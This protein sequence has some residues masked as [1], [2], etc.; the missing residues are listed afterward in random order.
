MSNDGVKYDDGKLRY[1][2]LPDWAI[3]KL[4]EVYTI[5][6]KK[7]GDH[8]YRK[9]MKWS[10]IIAAM[11]RHL[12]KAKRGLRYDLTD[13][14]EHLSSVAWC[15]LTL[16]EYQHYGLGED[17]R[18]CSIEVW[19]EYLAGLIDGDGWIGIQKVSSSKRKQKATAYSP[20]ISITLTA[21][22]EL[23][24]RIQAKYGGS[25]YTKKPYKTNH[26]VAYCWQLCG[27]TKIETLLTEVYPFLVLKKQQAD[28]VLDFLS[29]VIP[30]ER[31]HE[32]Y[33]DNVLQ[34]RDNYYERI[35][36]LNF[37]GR[38]FKKKEINRST[39]KDNVRQIEDVIATIT[40]G[41]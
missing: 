16:M 34:E 19:P 38:D 13:T 7:Y 30:H 5:G 22:K 10:R 21:Q 24:Q 9:G 35:K 8:N 41:G 6:A 23:L 11:M 32:G 27:N 28:I 40:Q 39:S 25:I 3:E 18:L 20:M 36:V 15:A 33:T 17:D 12:S 1:D 2:L 29:T 14:Q 31:S 4:V 26:K 37:R